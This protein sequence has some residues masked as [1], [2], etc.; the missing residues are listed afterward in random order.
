MPLSQKLRHTR[1][2]KLSTFATGLIWRGGVAD[3]VTARQIGRMD[4]WLY[5]GISGLHALT[6]EEDGANLPDDLAH[7]HWIGLLGFK[8]AGRM[9]K[10]QSR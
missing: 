2:P 8:R 7:G 6:N 3:R 9:S 1:R 4:V 10:W 5:T